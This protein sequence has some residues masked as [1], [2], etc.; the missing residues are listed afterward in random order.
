MRKLTLSTIC[1]MCKA[2]MFAY[3]LRDKTHASHKMEDNVPEKEKLRRL[4]E[5]I[6]IYKNRLREKN[7]K[8]EYGQLRL[9]LVEGYSTKVRYYLV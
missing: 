6:E 2:F 4:A 5:V 1:T 3:S 7:M 8:E 9:V